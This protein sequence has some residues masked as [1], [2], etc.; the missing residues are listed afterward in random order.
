LQ[1]RSIERIAEEKT[2]ERERERV[3]RDETRRDQKGKQK[4]DRSGVGFGQSFRDFA[5]E[6]VTGLGTQQLANN[7]FAFET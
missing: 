2:E 3:R 6:C 1:Q 5:D 7:I 4:T